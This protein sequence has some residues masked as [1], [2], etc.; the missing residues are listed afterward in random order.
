MNAPIHEGM[1]PMMGKHTR[2]QTQTL[3]LTFKRYYNEDHKATQFLY[4]P[5]THQARMMQKFKI[6]KSIYLC[7][8]Q[9]L[10]YSCYVCAPYT[11]QQ[12]FLVFLS[13]VAPFQSR[14][15]QISNVPNILLKCLEQF[16]PLPQ[17]K[18]YKREQQIL[19]RLG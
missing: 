18:Q 14:A 7:K 11:K 10:E 8:L 4:L 2:M 12:A 16:S 15:G 13:V 19:R 9:V 5:E 6:E 17:S 3:M 1:G